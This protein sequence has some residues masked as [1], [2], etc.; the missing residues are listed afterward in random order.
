MIYRDYVP[1]SLGIASIVQELDSD[2]KAG[3]SN[4]ID[5]LDRRPWSLPSHHLYKPDFRIL[6]IDQGIAVFVLDW[7]QGVIN[8]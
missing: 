4:I 5:V 3:V 1:G 6:D 8:I 7:D 2:I